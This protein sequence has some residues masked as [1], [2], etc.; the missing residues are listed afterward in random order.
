MPPLA[1]AEKPEPFPV[2]AVPEH[3]AAKPPK[4]PPAAFVVLTVKLAVV[5]SILVAAIGR[6]FVS[7]PESVK[8]EI[9]CAVYAGVVVGKAPETVPLAS[10]MG[11][12]K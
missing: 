5:L 9:I 3:K 1:L 4:G 7:T 12:H 11:F 2:A 6:V 10:A 8:A